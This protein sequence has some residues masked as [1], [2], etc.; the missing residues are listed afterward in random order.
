MVFLF[1]CVS[2][3]LLAC[4]PQFFF[5]CASVRVS[6]GEEGS[7]VSVCLGE[8]GFGGVWACVDFSR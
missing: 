3:P 5:V 2:H 8:R 1:V 7:G 6:V 4:V